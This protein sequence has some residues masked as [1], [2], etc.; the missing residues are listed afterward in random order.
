VHLQALKMSLD[1][2]AS[3]TPDISTVLAMRQEEAAVQ[4]LNSQKQLDRV[5]AD[6]QQKELQWHVIEARFQ[7]ELSALSSDLAAA[8]DAQAS[9]EARMLDLVTE[10]T[11]RD[12]KSAHDTEVRIQDIKRFYDARIELLQAESSAAAKC[13][14]EAAAVAIATVRDE[15]SI[16]LLSLTD[17][18]R[19]LELR[20]STFSSHLSAEQN[21]AKSLQAEHERMSASLRMENDKIST[22]LLAARS[23]ISNFIS[24]AAT[25]KMDIRNKEQAMQDMQTD[26]I[27]MRN[28]VALAIREKVALEKTA[29]FLQEQLQH[30]V[31]SATKLDD[32]LKK[33]KEAAGALRHASSKMA[34]LEVRVQQLAQELHASVCELADARASAA[35]SCQAL[36]T[37]SHE[38]MTTKDDHSEQC[39]RYENEIQHLKGHLKETASCKVAAEDQVVFLN[40]EIVV[41]KQ[42]IDDLNE[43]LT[44]QQKNAVA[45]AE[46]TRE[47]HLKALQ[48]VKEQHN[49]QSQLLAD[50]HAQQ[51][52]LWQHTEQEL[53][54]K[55]LE[56][57]QAAVAALAAVDIQKKAAEADAAALRHESTLLAE[58]VR[59]RF[60]RC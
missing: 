26:L 23:D 29:D 50:Q 18:C 51:K 40:K 32:D 55:L 24:D 22:A 56:R 39:T 53:R 13:A 45:G 34:G 8:K 20:C 37:V 47:I 43:Q 15:C 59:C 7:Q 48:F 30:A 6:S 38:L 36:D 49:H 52:H 54:D 58:Q 10:F 25:L 17:A 60:G 46:E 41:L 1:G 28:E 12:I 19:A 4:L 9:A 27:Q 21:A 31:A 35:A 16:Q 33:E 42:K 11:E 3:S 5:I 44:E 2:A 57:K 14:A